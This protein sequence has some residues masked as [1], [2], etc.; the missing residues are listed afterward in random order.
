MKMPVIP[1]SNTFVRCMSSDAAEALSVPEIL[2]YEVNQDGSI[3]YGSKWSFF[4]DTLTPSPEQLQVIEHYTRTLLGYVREPNVNP[5]PGVLEYNFQF[6]TL[7]DDTTVRVNNTTFPLN[8]PLFTF[9]KND[10]TGLWELKFKDPNLRQ[11]PNLTNNYTI[12]I[13]YRRT[14]PTTQTS[15]VIQILEMDST[16]F[17]DKAVPASQVMTDHDTLEEVLSYY[18]V[19]QIQTLLNNVQYLD[20]GYRDRTSEHNKKYRELRYRLNN[21]SKKDLNFGLEFILDGEVRLGYWTAETIGVEGLV[22]LNGIA[23]T[24]VKVDYVPEGDVDPNFWTLN[25]T[26]HPEQTIWWVKAPVSGKG[27]APR[28]KL[29]SKNQEAFSISAITWVYR[30]MYVR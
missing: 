19:R 15:R 23:Y 3:Q 10:T 24:N 11:L 5:L 18:P 17:S 7:P 27:Y 28:M 8:N 1:E 22:Y 6:S 13:S 20:T 4:G 2:P 14:A 25:Q 21:Q 12:T 26:D 16:G 9:T 29:L 30:M